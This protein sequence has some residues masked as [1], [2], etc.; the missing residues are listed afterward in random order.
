M[1]LAFWRKRQPAGP[2]PDV[3]LRMAR[4]R[5]QTAA[6]VAKDALDTAKESGERARENHI[7]PTLGAWFASERTPRPKMPPR[8]K[9]A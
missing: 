6:F 2:D 3:Q 9:S 7:S 4:A 5:A 8:R 1:R